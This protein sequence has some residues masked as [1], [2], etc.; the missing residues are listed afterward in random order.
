MIRISQVTKELNIGVSTLVDFLHRRG[1]VDV[2]DNLNQKITDEQYLMLVCEFGVN[3]INI[4]SVELEKYLTNCSKRPDIIGKTKRKD[5]VVGDSVE[6]T[7]I[8]GRKLTGKILS[9]REFML[10]EKEDGGL[11]KILYSTISECKKCPQGGAN[12][13]E[14]ANNTVEKCNEKNSS[15]LKESLDNQIKQPNTNIVGRKESGKNYTTN[16]NIEKSEDDNYEIK[17]PYKSKKAINRFADES[18]NNSLFSEDIPDNI[19]NQQDWNIIGR[20]ES[21]KIQ[22]PNDEIDKLVDDIYELISNINN[23]LYYKTG[24]FVFEPTNSDID[25]YKCIK[26]ICNSKAEFGDF[27]SAIYLM[28]YERSKSNGFDK[29]GNEKL[30]P[31]Q[32][33][34]EI[35]KKIDN[36]QNGR[37]RERKFFRIIEP[38]RAAFDAHMPEK[39]GR[40]QNQYSV[41]E[42][43][44]L[45][46][47]NRNDP[48]ADEWPYLQIG[49]LNLFK[50]ELIIIQN[51]VFSI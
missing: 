37:F 34:Y 35:E 48:V 42:A 7:L 30:I 44:E 18:N 39:I 50:N 15:D 31:G 14:S 4:S 17:W 13:F 27:L 38:L 51:E 11:V 28:Y 40:K 36:F 45:L 6:L 24:N 22:T 19:D 43:L 21:E 10:F 2:T 47:G 9:L 3:R 23:T 46:K 8:T 26:R 16:E 1:F 32:R 29:E 12:S 20:V 25:N 49:A 5:L 33:I 41:G